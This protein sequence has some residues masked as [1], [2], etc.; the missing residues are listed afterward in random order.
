MTHGNRQVEWRVK[1]TTVDLGCGASLSL[2]GEGR[3]DWLYI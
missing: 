1:V 3:N 2:R